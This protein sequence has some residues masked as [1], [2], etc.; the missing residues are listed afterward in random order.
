MKEERASHHLE[1]VVDVPVATETDGDASVY[2]F[3][4]WRDPTAD[5]AVRERHVAHLPATL[6]DD[7]SLPLG[8]LH[9][10]A[11]EKVGAGDTHPVIVFEGSH[12]ELF[13][14]P[15]RLVHALVAVGVVADAMVGSEFH[16][17]AYEL[18]GTRERRMPAHEARDKIASPAR[19]DE[20]RVLSE[21]ERS[22][23]LA[24]P[25]GCFEAQKRTDSTPFRHLLL[26]EES[27][28][29]RVRRFE[30]VVKSRG[31]RP[32]HLGTHPVGGGGDHV[33][34]EGVFDLWPPVVV[35]EAPEPIGS[36]IDRDAVCEYPIEV[37]VGVDETR[38]CH[39]IWR[40]DDV[41]VWVGS[42]QLGMRP[43]RIDSPAGHPHAVARARCLG[44]GRHQPV[45]KH[46]RHIVQCA[47][48]PHARLASADRVAHGRGRCLPV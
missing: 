19:L 47:T 31:A 26:R 42:P 20:V 23:L 45:G 5:L 7:L 35:E 4:N 39:P 13:L 15:G 36:S 2:Q 3:G 34:F 30:D 41:I 8:K 18:L 27:L 28:G 44:R 33:D 9:A 32:E 22:D 24:G 12:P 37:N 40:L 16:R 6:G 1:E 43:D 46:Q 10:L 48:A 38:Q 29:K 25:F 14:A 21:S 17:S 11:R